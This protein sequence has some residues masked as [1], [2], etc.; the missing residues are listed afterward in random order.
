VSGQ[1]GACFP[2]PA[3]VA[4]VGPRVVRQAVAGLGPC[5]VVLVGAAGSGKST[6]ARELAGDGDRVLSVDELCQLAGRDP[7]DEVAAAAAVEALLVLAGARLR[8]GLSVIADGVHVLPGD[9]RPLAAMARRYGVPAVAVVMV[10]PLETCLER[11]ARRP[12]PAAG[13]RWGSRV[14]EETVRGQHALVLR[15]V[16]GL[17]AEGFDPVICARTSQNGETD[18]AA[19]LPEAVTGR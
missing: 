17:A 6:L 14:P 4:A 7:Y 3:V 16:P 1:E 19:G 11:N 9:R 5:V 18:G 8:R 15:S 10:T 12:A 2:A 13:R